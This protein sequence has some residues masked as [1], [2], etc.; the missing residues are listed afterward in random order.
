M[1]M[2]LIKK[3]I[4]KD[5]ATVTMTSGDGKQEIIFHLK[6]DGEDNL[7][8]RAEFKPGSQDQEGLH[9]QLADAFATNILGIGQPDPEE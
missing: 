2:E 8:S 7:E 9:V 3:D 5:K 4:N 1:K 6:W